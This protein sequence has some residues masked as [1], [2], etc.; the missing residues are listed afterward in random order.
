MFKLIITGNNSPINSRNSPKNREDSSSEAKK[1]KKESSGWGSYFRKFG[2]NLGSSDK[3]D[4]QSPTSGSSMFFYDNLASLRESR[5][6]VPDN[7]FRAPGSKIKKNSN[8]GGVTS[9]TLS[10][11]SAEFVPASYRMNRAVGSNLK[12]DNSWATVDDSVL[13]SLRPPP[14][15][16]K[17]ARSIWGGDDAARIKEDED[18]W[19]GSN[20]S[21]FDFKNP[22]KNE[23]SYSSLLG[24]ASRSNDVR[25][26]IFITSF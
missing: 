17:P 19:S 3:T 8:N 21:L 14:G 2:I 6:V 11:D 13:D 26:L 20:S 18:V 24:G 4:E 1:S 22:F 9:S 15:F 25:F 5:Q 23:S 12:K 10:P 16:S 7:D